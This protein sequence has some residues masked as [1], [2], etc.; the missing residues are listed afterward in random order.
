MIRVLFFA[1]LRDELG[2]SETQ[3]DAEGVSDLENLLNYLIQQQPEW[4]L[5]LDKPLMMAVNQQMAEL[6]TEIKTGDEVAF[7]P[8]VTGG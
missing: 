1:R 6:K 4:Q 7:F 5:F 8:P 3:V 2:V